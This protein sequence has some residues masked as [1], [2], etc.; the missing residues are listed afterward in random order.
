MIALALFSPALAAYLLLRHSWGRTPSEVTPALAL[1]AAP[2]L[3]VAL[4]SCLYFGLLLLTGGHRQAVRLDLAFWIIA[5]CG[6]LIATARRSGL[7]SLRDRDSSDHSIKR[8][9]LEVMVAALGCLVLAV[10]AGLSFWLYSTINPHGEWDAWAIWNLRARAIFRGVP[11]WSAVFS[12]T[13]P[14]ADYPPL[15]PVAVA[16]LWAYAGREQLIAPAVVALPFSFSSTAIII[17]SV[18]QLRGWASGWLTDWLCSR[19]EPSCSRAL[20][21]APMCRLASSYSWRSCSSRWRGK[22]AARARCS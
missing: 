11:D 8:V 22:R 18:G 14:G 3:G 21:S 7:R 17:V 19:H 4:S 9:Q 13:F 1:S 20:G 2:G 10:V 15:V 5:D 6:L 16:R 12:P